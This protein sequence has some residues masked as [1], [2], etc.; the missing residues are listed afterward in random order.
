MWVVNTGTRGTTVIKQWR[1]K[2]HVE[3]FILP[4]I[5]TLY[6]ASSVRSLAVGEL[7]KPDLSLTHV[8][9]VAVVFG[10]L[11]CPLRLVGGRRSASTGI[12]P[13]GGVSS[14][15]PVSCLG[16]LQCLHWMP[17]PHMSIQVVLQSCS[18]GTVR[19]W[20]R[21]DVCVGQHVTLEVVR[22]SETH[23][24]ADRTDPECRC[25]CCRRRCCCGATLQKKWPLKCV[26]LAWLWVSSH[27]TA[28]AVAAA[29]LHNIYCKHLK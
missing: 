2:N 7:E 13:R 29:L 23:L 20:E 21:P 11:I 10:N 8:N 12:T 15:I 22:A 16:G 4:F 26:I 5:L 9:K 6:S 1:K 14:S 19:T 3:L 17:Q 28:A 24:A 27:Y 18:V 25:H